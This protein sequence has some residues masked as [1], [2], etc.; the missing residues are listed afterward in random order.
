MRQSAKPWYRKSKNSWYV[1]LDGKA[2]NL[3]VKGE[4]NEREAV[5]AWHRVM[6]GVEAS[7]EPKAVMTAPKAVEAKPE[8]VATKPARH[9]EGPA[10][11]P[12]LV[13][14]FLAERQGR[15][16]PE[17]YRGYSIHLKALAEAFA[18]VKPDAL[19]VAMV[20]RFYKGRKDWSSS[21]RCG[22]VGTVVSLFKWAVEEGRLDRSPVAGI[23]KPQK[24]SRGR[25]SLISHDDHAKLVAAAKGDWKAFLSLLWLTGCRP[26]EL[27]GLT[28]EAVDL[29]N[30]VVVL[31]EHKTAEQTGSDRLI[32]LP[33]EAVPLLRDVMTRRP[34]GLLFP[35]ERGRRLNPKNVADRMRRLCRRAGVSALAY[36]YRH[37]FATDALSQGVPDATVAAL[38]GHTGT[39]MLHRHYS[40]LTSKTD[41]LRQAVSK[42]R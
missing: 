9:E 2:V 28:A 32:V 41:V 4:Q 20:E 39:V 8:A 31:A 1:W 38:L 7:G 37:S 26:G 6:A 3:F 5:K 30:R 14:A 17:T 21:Y 25:R 27:T 42:V 19:T 36:G 22:F 35:G 34:S 13:E 40:H 23:R 18:T 29:T 33:E 10:S 24:Q 16:K 11:L 15:V 12:S